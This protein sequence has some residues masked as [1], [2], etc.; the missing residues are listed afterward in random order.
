MLPWGH[1]AVGYL[2]YAAVCRYT[3]G[4][5]RIPEG[6][7]VL[8]LA[9]GTQFADLV[10]KPLAWSLSVLPTGRSLAHSL[11]V[12]AALLALLDRFAASADRRDLSTAFALGYLAHLAGDVIYGLGSGLEQLQF[13]LWPVIP[14]PPPET[15][16]TILEVLIELTLSPV[17]LLESALFVATT[18]LWLSHRAP[19]LWLCL[20]SVRSLDP[21]G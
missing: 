16:H 17:G 2:L 7:A 5:K 20:E 11:F 4:G 14:Q 12:A 13:L 15:S 18:G 19:G 1:A 9:V 10:D 3:E 6:A 8:A 21:R